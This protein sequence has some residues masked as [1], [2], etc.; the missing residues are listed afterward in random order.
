MIS[1][2]YLNKIGIIHDNIKFELFTYKSGR[3]LKI[4]SI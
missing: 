1:N 4:D 2:L 3:K